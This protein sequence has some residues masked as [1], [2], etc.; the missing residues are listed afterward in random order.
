MKL[1][2]AGPRLGDIKA[3]S[4]AMETFGVWIGVEKADQH[5]KSVLNICGRA[6]NPHAQSNRHNS[7]SGNSPRCYITRDVPAVPTPPLQQRFKPFGDG[8]PKTL[9]LSVWAR[10]SSPA[11]S[12]RGH[13][14]VWNKGRHGTYFVARFSPRLSPMQR[15]ARLP[16]NDSRF[17]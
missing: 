9:C 12:L 7:T 14:A 16:I 17:R 1:N 11:S 13:C 4:M 3:R 8:P 10:A 5:P 15:H 6:E 2:L